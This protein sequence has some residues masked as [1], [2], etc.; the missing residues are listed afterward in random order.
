[1]DVPERLARFLTEATLDAVLG[2]GEAFRARHSR[3]VTVREA[4][5]GSA[6]HRH[7]ETAA[8]AD[9]SFPEEASEPGD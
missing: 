4:L 5:Y 7:V 9:A 3:S 1:M 6:V 2:L 8:E